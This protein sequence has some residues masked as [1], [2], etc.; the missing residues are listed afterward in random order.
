MSHLNKHEHEDS[1]EHKLPPTTE[2]AQMTESQPLHDIPV[3]ATGSSLLDRHR[4][5]LRMEAEAEAEKARTEAEKRTWRETRDT[6]I[7]DAFDFDHSTLGK[8]DGI[9]VTPVDDVSTRPKTPRNSLGRSRSASAGRTHVGF[10][11]DEQPSNSSKQKM[12]DPP[13][14]RQPAYNDLNDWLGQN[15]REQQAWHKW[16]P[17]A[18]QWSDSTCP[19]CPQ[20]QPQTKTTLSPDEQTIA[21]LTKE[22]QK[23]KADLRDAVTLRAMTN[24]QTEDPLALEGIALRQQALHD[25]A[26]RLDNVKQIRSEHETH[27]PIPDDHTAIHTTKQLMDFLPR[28][29]TDLYTLLTRLSET[30][31]QQQLSHADVKTL[32][33]HSL[34]GDALRL[35]RS[36]R[37]APLGDIFKAL[38]SRFLPTH[39]VSQ[40]SRDLHLFQREQGE[41]IRSAMERCMFLIRES[42]LSC[43][44]EQREGRMASMSASILLR[45]VSPAVAAWLHHQQDRALRK[46]EIL[47]TE[48]LIQLAED[49]EAHPSFNGKPPLVTNVQVSNTEAK[50]ETNESSTIQQA[51]ILREPTLRFDRDTR[52][53]SSSPRQ[54]GRERSRSPSPYRDNRS[55]RRFNS[56]TRESRSRSTRDNR[57]EDFRSRSRDARDNTYARNRDRSS[58]NYK[59][60]SYN[61]S[62]SQPPM[63]R[64]NN[65]RSQYRQQGYT[66]S[67]YNVRPRQ[68]KYDQYRPFYG[69]PM[70]EN[71]YRWQNQKKPYP[72]NMPLAYQAY[73][74]IMHGNN[75]TYQ[76]RAQTYDDIMPVMEN[77]GHVHQQV[78]LPM[79]AHL[80]QYWQS[81]T[82]PRQRSM[83][84]QQNRNR[85]DRRNFSRPPPSTT[86]PRMPLN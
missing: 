77:R 60:S 72:R 64:S 27:F 19:E 4:E 18:P 63:E 61:R 39:S 69:P 43:P 22:V 46:G 58:P 7:D 1:E 38:E 74:P 75:T 23:L 15:P 54:E 59:N 45:I 5:L 30:A 11:L 29:T 55:E 24:A 82:G 44:P 73:Q 86:P 81:P 28:S 65:F 47:T 66:P 40:Y 26:R 21:D 2:G 13:L 32:L 6:D 48:E 9:R 83:N 31:I 57:R 52:R 37:Y 68:P 8:T 50:S 20:P 56:Q 85:V 78:Y 34:T 80:R 62:Q 67:T 42:N 53:T 17:S 3:H 14:T 16:R 49:S 41:T 36:M 71:P 51:G 33:C 12:P 76:N 84:R 25:A 35:Y 70:P 10:N 79:P